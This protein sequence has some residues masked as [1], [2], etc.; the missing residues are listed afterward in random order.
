[1]TRRLH[2]VRRHRDPCA[3][4]LVLHGGQQRSTEPTSWR[5]LSV[6][7]SRLFASAVAR[8]GAPHRI[9]VSFLRYARRGWNDGAPVRDAR[10]AL[11]TVRAEHPG[12]PVGLLGYSMGGRVA[13]HLADGVETVV[14]AAAWVDEADLSVL[15]PP[16]SGRVLLLHG[17]EDQMTAAEGSRLAA[18]RLRGLGADARARTDLADTHGMMRHRAAWHR[19]ASAHLV[20]VLTGST[21]AAEGRGAD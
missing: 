10:W 7:R 20:E 12:L 3:H 19:L 5:Q 15:R 1:M 17:S 14:T 9:D 8:A 16:A 2:T 18:E 4:V 11:E 13:L 21:C 6:L